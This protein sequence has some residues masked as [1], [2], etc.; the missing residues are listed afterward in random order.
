M[1]VEV[2]D[3]GSALAEGWNDG[4]WDGVRYFELGTGEVWDDGMGVKR[5]RI[6]TE[7]SRMSKGKASVIRAPTIEGVNRGLFVR[8]QQVLYVVDAIDGDL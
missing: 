6:G 5:R 4:S 3:G 7:D 8:P 1:G 2:P